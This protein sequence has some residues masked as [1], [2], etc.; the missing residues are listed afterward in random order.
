MVDYNPPLYYSEKYNSKLFEYGSE[1][2]L[3]LEQSDKR[4]LRLSGGIVYGNTTYSSGLNI[5]G[6]LSLNGSNVDLSSLTYLTGLSPGTASVSKALVLDNTGNISGINTLKA[7]YL[8]LNNVGNILKMNN[9]TITMAGY[10]NESILPNSAYFGTTTNHNLIFQTNATTRLYITNTGNFGFGTPNSTGTYK[11]DIAGSLN[12]SS[13]YI[14]NSIL[15]ISALS[16]VTNGSATA[17][18]ALILDSSRN[19]SNIN[20]LK[21]TSDIMIPNTSRFIL[22]RDVSTGD[23]DSSISSD[24]TNS[25]ISINALRGNG[26]VFLNTNS[27]T[28]F[29]FKINNASAVTHQLCILASNGNIGIAQ[30]TPAYKLDIGGTLNCTS[31]NFTNTT[32]GAILMT[33]YDAAIASGAY[34]HIMSIGKSATQGENMRMSYYWS[35]TA[36]NVGFYLSFNNNTSLPAAFYCNQYG[37]VT[38]AQSVD[39][40]VYKQNGTILDFSSLGSTSPYLTGITEGTA[41]ASKALI[42]NT[43]KDMGGLR[44]LSITGAFIASTSI[45]SPGISTDSINLV[46]TAITAT[47]TELNYNDITTLGVQQ[48]S[49]VLTSDSNG[50]T[51]FTSGSNTTNQLKFF[52]DTA[53]RD[54]IRIF[55][56][57]DASPLVIGSLIDAGTSINR[58]W[59]V[60]EVISGLDAGTDILSATSQPVFK[61]TTKLLNY[62]TFNFEIG[63]VFGT[64]WTGS[65]TTWPK[66]VTLGSYGNTEYMNIFCDSNRLSQNGNILLSSLSKDVIISGNAPKTGMVD[67]VSMYSPLYCTRLSVG[68]DIDTARLANFTDS[69]M[70]T[71]T[72]RYITFGRANSSNN[73][74]EISYQY[75]SAAQ[76]ILG[77]GHYGQAAYLN[78]LSNG[79]LGLGTNAPR[80]NFEINGTTSGITI[81]AGATNY[82]EITRSGATYNLV[83]PASFTLSMYVSGSIACGSLVLTS[84]KRLKENIV[85]IPLDYA[86]RML[87]VKAKFFNMKKNTNARKEVGYIAQDFLQDGVEL[88]E[89]VILTD[90][91]DL[92]KESNLDIEDVSYSLE[93]MKI[94]ALQNEM[95]RDLYEEITV[96]KNRLAKV[97]TYGPLLKFLSK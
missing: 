69:S 27:T 59:P 46:G 19:I 6:N 83:G 51:K 87:L 2:T 43:D 52:S 78:L 91:K 36:A 76:S 35:T 94:T 47:G 56:S 74:A 70:L 89:L 15:D 60:L 3:T 13:L 65:P 24:G 57:N 41:L 48:A 92:K 4:Y 11:V 88:D 82:C 5:N 39:S 7:G 26:T 93:Y 66:T 30:N 73:Q 86:K 79:R 37:N 18:K 68:T 97:E 31:Q 67:G 20:V 45:A 22:A 21:T 72:T 25:N 12:C 84:D 81:G 34:K 77:F 95:I 32:S 28:G 38:V 53:N 40:P 64:P 10:I 80:C 96:L 1:E 54:S 62:G 75:N 14:N 90:N 17:S 63:N 42:V 71:G 50:V 44:N 49:K 29:S 61:V 16:G 9:G 23:I 33:N 85:D 55:R 8:E 58:T